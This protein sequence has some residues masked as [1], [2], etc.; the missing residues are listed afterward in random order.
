MK[1][2][3][4]TRDDVKCLGPPGPFVEPLFLLSRRERKP[5]V[6]RGLRG[7]D[8]DDGP[9]IPKR[10]WRESYAI[11]APKSSTFGTGALRES[12]M[13][14]SP[15]LACRRRNRPVPDV[16]RSETGSRSRSD[17]PS[18]SAGRRAGRPIAVDPAPHAFG[19]RRTLPGMRTG[20]R[21]AR[22]AW[23]EEVGSSTVS[24]HV[25]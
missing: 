15:I 14:T 5:I 18:C 17:V 21:L 9:R 1:N 12:E 3:A 4:D 25:T 10:R 7:E 20:D 11:T 13:Q 24:G 19:W 8:E 6:C 16:R 2:D 23:R 22:S